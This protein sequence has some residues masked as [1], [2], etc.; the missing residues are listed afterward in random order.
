[1]TSKQ[2]RTQHSPAL[3]SAALKLAEPIGVAA[4]A[5]E[6]SLD[7]SQLYNWRSQLHNQQTSSDRD[8]EM[9]TEIAR[10]KRPL[11]ERDE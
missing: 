3:R 11:A 10:R 4:A 6:L 2:P 8:L 1:S 5:R 7:E 9:S